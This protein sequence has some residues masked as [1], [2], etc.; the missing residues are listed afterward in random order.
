MKNLVAAVIVLTLCSFSLAQSPALNEIP[1]QE[2]AP[3]SQLQNNSAGAASLNPFATSICSFTFTSGTK[4]TFLKYCVTANGNITQFQSPLGFEHIALGDVSEGYG[5][6]DGTSNLQYDDY[7][8]AGAT[9][10][11]NPAIVL[12]RSAIS[13]VIARTTSD[14][15]WT[16]TQ[17]FTQLAGNS[18]V[19]VA[20][21]LKNNSTIDRLVFLLRFADVDAAG[22]FSNNLDGT[23]DSA[24][25]WNSAG[26]NSFGLAMR[27]KANT[28]FAHAGF[29]QNI[30]G[31][32]AMPWRM[33]PE[34]L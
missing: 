3:A 20:M 17:T 18:S 32:P 24:F 16:L 22:T 13:V 14:G 30:P 31:G 12:S 5:I 33:P 1:S 9:L 11:W 2:A 34:L 26:V 19:D 27:N 6:C 7:A 21:N 4:E 8:D 23:T 29:A 15:V 28:P 25:G 10:N